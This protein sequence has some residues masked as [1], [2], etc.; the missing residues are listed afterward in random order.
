M[1]SAGARLRSPGHLA[2]TLLLLAA[3]SLTLAQPRPAGSPAPAKALPG[4]PN[5]TPAS[6]RS[7]A[8]TGWAELTPAQ[9]QALRPLA[10]NW[11]T[12]SEPHKKKWI[13]L[14]QNYASMPPAEQA[15]LHSR[16]TDWAALSP[17]QRA[18]ARLNFAKAKAVSPD[19]RKAQWQAY[20]ALSPEERRK[21]ATTGDSARP[22]GA[23]TAVK[24][25]A[26]QKLTPI[27]R[28]KPE[29]GSSL[30]ERK[31]QPTLPPMGNQVDKNT[32]LPQPSPLG[33]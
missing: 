25:V 2:A 22:V 6:V 18:Q 23:A 28:T 32:L 21:L 29:K 27:P 12:L 14:S 16:M 4:A 30:A 10:A 11:G 15:R 8:A 33:Y 17:A 9:Q 1:P 31:R 20:Q 5:G 3:C 13:S 7:S 19:E 26:P 24:P